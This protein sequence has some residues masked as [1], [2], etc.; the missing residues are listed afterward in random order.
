MLKHATSPRN[1]SLTVAALT[2]L[3]HGRGS[4]RALT[5][6][7]MVAFVYSARS[8][9]M[10]NPTMESN[11]QTSR[12][13]S[14]ALRP[15]PLAVKNT[16]RPMLRR[17]LRDA[18]VVALVGSVL[19]GVAETVTLR[20]VLGGKS[21]T[22]PLPLD[23]LIAIAGRCMLTHLCLWTP[24]MLIVAVAAWLSTRRRR[25]G[26]FTPVLAAVFA[27]VSG[28]VV[29]GGALGF[30][31]RLHTWYV[32]AACLISLAVATCG[33]FALRRACRR[34]ARKFAR[35][36]TR[37][38]LGV[39]A[40]ALVLGCAA[41]IRSPFLGSNGERDDSAERTSVAVKK[42]SPNVLWIVLDTTR[43][44]RLGP[45]G[46][47]PNTTPFLD[48]FASKALVAEHAVGNGMWTVPTHAAM[49]TGR[50][51]REHGVDHRNLW[52]D[53]GIPTVAEVLSKA[54]YATAFFTNNPLVS[55]DTNLSKGFQTQHVVYHHRRLL[56]FSLDYWLERLGVPPPLPWL[57]LD[58]GAR[59]TRE[60]VNR[61]L[62]QRD[63]RPLLVFV[64]LMEAHLPYQAP[65]RYREMFMN[66]RQ[67]RRSYVL[68]RRAFGNV[69]VAFDFTFNLSETRFAPDE[70]VEILRRQYE[71]ALRYLDDQVRALVGEFE[72]R[73]MLDN[74]L[75]VIASDHGEQLDTH[76]MW[77][78]RFLTYQDLT[79]VALMVRRPG[80]V[81]ARRIATPVQLS[82]LYAT[83]LSAAGVAMPDPQPADSHDLFATEELDPNRVA[84][85]ECGGPAPT[86]LVRFTDVTTPDIL[87]R[88][89]QQ[90]AAVGK[91]Y[92]LIRSADGMRELYDLERDPGE[93]NNLID[94]MPEQAARLDARIREWRSRVPAYRPSSERAG[95]LSPEVLRALRDLGYV[96]DR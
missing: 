82:D 43:A 22:A 77:G 65:R 24:V 75:V 23:L 72:Q 10:T 8:G 76:G 41:L 30:A 33:Y 47:R 59:L 90:I 36:C 9:G 44:D 14:H 49:F 96:G 5:P 50:S 28:V 31:G 80:Q 69:A 71:A 52:L 86:T 94:A 56:R 87:H 58:F 45:F 3:P 15:A 38:A 29:S 25:E 70:D 16:P 32:V 93:L 92:K 54:G 37:S 12:A 60:L 95:E 62:D 11:T 78:H 88:A 81:A 85:I 79:H 7:V 6:K 67:V 83:V 2:G 68:R 51:L 18:V 27:A 4:D 13:Q 74:T 64:N 84:I 42:T 35:R 53:E 19:W 34:P 26:S 66:E 20:V 55:A 63:E 40:I 73:G 89:T 1:R 17:T 91:R 48:S 46:G 57:D 21:A 61:R 39:A